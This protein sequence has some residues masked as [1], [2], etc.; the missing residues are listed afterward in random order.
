MKIIG[1]GVRN[2][3]TGIIEEIGILKNKYMAG[4][5]YQVSIEAEEVIK[6]LTIGE[7]IAVNGTC[8]TVVDFDDYNFTADVM[9]ETLNSTN[10]KELEKGE[11]VNLELPLTP[12]DFMGGH[13]VT[14]HIDGTGKIE[15]I[16]AEKNARLVDI[17]FDPD[18][19]KYMVDKGSV[20]LNG[21]SLTIARIKQNTL[22]VSLIPETWNK[23]NFSY[24]K[25]GD[26]INIETDLIGKYVL[27]FVQ[28]EENNNQLQD[29]S[30]LNKNFLRENGFI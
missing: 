2:L 9:P 19:Q 20:A 3:F 24:I 10:L 29:D 4:D 1:N 28:G 8:L 27:Q 23:T 22:R 6:K 30:R 5:K 17:S 11:R 26:T 15:S 16:K 18:L 7:S 14:G 13:M 25:I 12:V 21:V